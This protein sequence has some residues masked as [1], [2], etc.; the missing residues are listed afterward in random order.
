MFNRLKPDYYV[1]SIYS[2]DFDKLKQKGIKSLIIDI[3]NTLMPWGAKQADDNV[4][5]LIDSLFKRGFKICLLSNSS[6]RRI[7]KFIGNIKIEYYSGIGIKPMK[8]MFKG[9]LNILNSLPGEVCCIGDQIFTDI[10]GAKRCGI[11]T[12]LVD[13][14][15]KKEFIATRYLRRLED[16]IRK[17]LNYSKEIMKYE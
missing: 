8:R 4:K 2:I 5:I 13:P 16:K 11:R 1:P 6:K 17:N 15:F 9:A 3:D 7:K 10:L 14:I 12:I